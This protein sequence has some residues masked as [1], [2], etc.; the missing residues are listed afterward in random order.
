[1]HELPQ[2]TVLVSDPYTLSIL[3]ARTGLESIVTYSNLD[4]LSPRAE[5]KLKS[6]LNSVFSVPRSNPGTGRRQ[7]CQSLLSLAK[8]GASELNYTY[9]VLNGGFPLIMSGAPELPD[10]TADPALQNGDQAQ[11]WAN[12]FVDPAS[13]V[14]WTFVAVISEKSVRWAN[15][16]VGERVGYF[17]M[18]GPLEP[19]MVNVLASVFPVLHNFDNRIIVVSI[20]CRKSG[21]R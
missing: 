13:Q 16:P 21:A 17:P 9:A 19:S 18:N 6:A 14:P 4:V 2:A 7:V 8:D 12:R 1:L 15:L 3:R 5:R 11:G 20:D 10:A